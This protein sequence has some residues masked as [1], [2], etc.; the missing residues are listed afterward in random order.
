M[1]RALANGFRVSGCISSLVSVYLSPSLAFD[2]GGS[3]RV[4]LFVSCVSHSWLVVSGCLDVFSLL[5]LGSH[6][7]SLTTCLPIHLSPNLC[8]FNHQFALVVVS[9]SFA[10]SPVCVSS[11][12][13]CC[14]FHLSPHSSYVFPSGGVLFI[15]VT[16]H[17]DFICD[18]SLFLFFASFVSSGCLKSFTCCSQLRWSKACNHQEPYDHKHAR[19]RCNGYGETVWVFGA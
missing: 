13:I 14:P 7:F 5:S 3:P 2:G 15:L 1:S 12:T 9:D 11:I 17:H 4:S 8:V 18:W 10:C 16:F 6:H 19:R